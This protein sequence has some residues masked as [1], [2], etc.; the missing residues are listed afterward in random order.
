MKRALILALVLLN[1]LSSAA[2]TPLVLLGI[3]VAPAVVFSAA[4][5]KG[6]ANDAAAL[7]V[8]IVIASSSPTCAGYASV[9]SGDLLVVTASGQNGGPYITSTGAGA[10][11]WTPVT[12]I[13]NATGHFQTWMWYCIVPSSGATTI[14]ATQVNGSFEIIGLAEY[15]STTGWQTPA[16]DQVSLG[17]NLASATPCSTG[18]SP[19]MTNANDLIVAICQT[20]NISETWG[21]VSGYTNRAGSSLAGIG[22]DL[23]WYDKTVTAAAT[24]SWSK[25]IT[26]DTTNAI[27]AGFRAGSGTNPCSLYS[28]LDG[29]G[30]T[31]GNVPTAANLNTFGQPFGPFSGV[32]VITGTAITYDTNGY[33]ALAT[34]APNLCNSGQYVDNA[35]VGFKYSTTIGGLSKL[36]LNLNQ[37][38]GGYPLNSA[39]VVLSSPVTATGW[40]CTTLP[41]T[42]TANMDFFALYAA[43]GSFNNVVLQAAGSG[44]T[45]LMEAGTGTPIAITSSTSCG[46]GGT[47]YQI[48]ISWIKGGTS[49]FT[50]YNSSG[51]SLGSYTKTSNSSDVNQFI[52]GNNLANSPTTGF[53]VYFDKI[54]L[55]YL[56]G[57]TFPLLE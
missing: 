53:G 49:T 21:A 43:D 24:Q 14:T 34:S 29:S 37:Y 10:C 48:A 40:F 36:T 44:V 28:L 42:A 2:Q 31:T 50:L 9:T 17:Q 22:D 56:S 5:V 30:G 39:Y 45:V 51:T 25:A 15:S 55:C 3:D 35:S 57:C 38:A 7:T 26:S 47:W 41:S 18:T 27:V 46:S 13:F 11:T 33:Q 32:W 19:A 12:G 52:V 8:S 4:F 23:G 1:A 20:W 6:C 16:Y 54:K